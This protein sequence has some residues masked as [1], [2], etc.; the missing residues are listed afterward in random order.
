MES[1]RKLDFKK[2]TSPAVS[3]WY[4]ARIAFYIILLTGLIAL[5]FSQKDKPK[6]DVRETK[7]IENVKITIEK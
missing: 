4:L 2:Y 7:K 5:F 6:K 1:K 3:K